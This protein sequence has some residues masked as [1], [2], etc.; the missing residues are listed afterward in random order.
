MYEMIAPWTSKESHF[1]AGKTTTCS[2]WTDLGRR[3]PPRKFHLV[4]VLTVF[5]RFSTFQLFFRVLFFS[6]NA[7]REAF[8][9]KSADPGA[10]RSGT[11][12]TK[13]YYSNVS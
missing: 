4:G 6:R 11:F 13:R 12:L 5:A 8:G 10:T 9:E 7:S 2:I 1:E 3:F